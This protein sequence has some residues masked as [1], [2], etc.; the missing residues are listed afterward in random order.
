[1]VVWLAFNILDYQ[2]SIST[3][4]SQRKQSKPDIL[5]TTCPRYV[6]D[7]WKFVHYGLLLRNGQSQ[8]SNLQCNQNGALVAISNFGLH[9]SVHTLL[10]ANE[11]FQTADIFYKAWPRYLFIMCL[12][13]FFFFQ[14]SIKICDLE[15]IFLEGYIVFQANFYFQM[16]W[17]IRLDKTY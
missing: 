9:Q 10:I 16:F 15:V 4:Y 8:N 12:V 14:I 17:S 3:C 11:Y 7:F 6:L 13:F 1:M 2:R 5:H